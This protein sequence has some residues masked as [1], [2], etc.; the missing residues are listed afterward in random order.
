VTEEGAWKPT[1]TLR[2]RLS[3]SLP[4]LSVTSFQAATSDTGKPMFTVKVQNASDYRGRFIAI[5]RRRGGLS[6]ATGLVA[7]RPILPGSVRT[8]TTTTDSVGSPGPGSATGE[9]IE[10]ELVWSSGTETTFLTDS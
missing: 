9:D 6:P 8:L 4:S 3:A 1:D 10:Y 7:S 2:E 5:L